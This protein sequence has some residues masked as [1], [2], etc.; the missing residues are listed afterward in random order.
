M[1]L[2]SD[3]IIIVSWYQGI[4]VQ[5]EIIQSHMNCNFF[6]NNLNI[7]KHYSAR[8]LTSWKQLLLQKPLPGNYNQKL[9]RW[10]LGVYIFIDTDFQCD[11]YIYYQY[12]R[13]GVL[14]TTRY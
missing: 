1:M 7:A 12:T 5:T 3:I 11:Y 13:P 8:W 10:N 6:E 2:K 14:W 9:W 4:G